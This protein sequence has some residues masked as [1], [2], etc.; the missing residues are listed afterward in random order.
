MGKALINSHLGNGQYSIT[1]YRDTSYAE[2]RIAE[3]E[4]LRADIEAEIYGT[5]GL[6]DQRD[7]VEYDYNQQTQEFE[8]WLDLWAQCAKQLPL[9]EDLNTYKANMERA[10]ETRSGYAQVLSFL[11]MQIAEKKAKALSALYEIGFLNTT[12]TNAK[13]MTAWCVD[14]WKDANHDPIPNGV[15]VGTIET[16]GA[17]LDNG[18]GWLP[19]VYINI[20]PSFPGDYAYNATRDHCVKALSSM[21]TASA[22]NN[23]CQ[24]LNAMTNN[25]QYAIGVL[26]AK[27]G[28]T[29]TVVLYGSSKV[30]NN[31]PTGYPFTQDGTYTV[32]LTSVPIEYMNCHG[33]AFEVNDRVVVE[34]SG[35]NRASPK[36]I[37]FADNPAVCPI[38]YTLTYT[39][40]TGGSITGTTPQTVAE[41]E[42]GTEVFASANSGYCFA[43]WSDYKLGAYRTDTNVQADISVTASFVQPST[44]WACP[45][46]VSIFLKGQTASSPWYWE[47]F[48]GDIAS[49]WNEVSEI[50]YLL[51]VYLNG[52]WVPFCNATFTEAVNMHR[53]F[54]LGDAVVGNP[55]PNSAVNKVQIL[56]ALFPNQT[57]GADVTYGQLQAYLGLGAVPN[58]LVL[59]FKPTDVYFE[60]ALQNN[61]ID[62]TILDPATKVCVLSYQTC[63]QINWP[64][65][66]TLYLAPGNLPSYDYASWLVISA[67]FTGQILDTFYGNEACHSPAVSSVGS[68]PGEIKVKHTSGAEVIYEMSTYENDVSYANPCTSP[69]TGLTRIFYTMKAAQ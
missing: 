1:Y 42:D 18:G 19:D 16:F 11:N 26:T 50:G 12:N 33:A 68:A 62:T 39:A 14:R 23:Y 8:Y 69:T 44:G 41:G 4:K 53:K 48:V 24:F 37:G 15:I 28:N 10:A 3:L 49:A 67:G 64:A 52:E 55:F 38:T 66:I 36:V 57:W 59:H 22:L 29:G 25:P 63:N 51:D 60:M 17:K 61:L 35:V 5:D 13:V 43:K 6:V 32:T 21:G 47:E 45:T 31:F 7:A 34:F 58:N 20:V 40:G 54:D 2:G 46:T 65:Q 27:S 30:S 9:C 56:N